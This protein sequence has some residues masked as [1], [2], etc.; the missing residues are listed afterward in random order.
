MKTL[1]ISL[2]ITAVLIC[3]S[4]SSHKQ[5]AAANAV[6]PD[7]RCAVEQAYYENPLQPAPSGKMPA[8]Y[9]APGNTVCPCGINNSDQG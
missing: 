5:I 2:V 4:C 7:C 6:N 8:L 3:A 9:G 1:S